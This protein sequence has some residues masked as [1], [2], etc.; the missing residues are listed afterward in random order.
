MPLPHDLTGRKVTY[1]LEFL[2]E[3][4]DQASHSFQVGAI[5]TEMENRLDGI[6]TIQVEHLST[7]HPQ[8]DRFVV[9]VRAGQTHIEI[10]LN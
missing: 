3:R 4:L 9:H 1:V 2:H 5:K 7:V 6:L 10:C 8:R